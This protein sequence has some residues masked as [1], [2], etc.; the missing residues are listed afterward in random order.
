LLVAVH[1]ARGETE[2][3]REVAQAFKEGK[4][5]P[6][7]KSTAVPPAE[8]SPAKSAPEEARAAQS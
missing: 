1:E 3:A 6:P 8:D 4:S 7:R 2:R 5:I